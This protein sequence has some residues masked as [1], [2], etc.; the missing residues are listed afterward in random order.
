M[1]RCLLEIIMLFSVSCD[2]I[3]GFFVASWRQ[4]ATNSDI[5]YCV[6]ISKKRLVSDSKYNK[7][8]GIQLPKFALADELKLEALDEDVCHATPI[9][10][11]SGNIFC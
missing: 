1:M 5:F 7:R 8:N 4:L 6:N 10:S 11:S 2:I 3:E 9:K